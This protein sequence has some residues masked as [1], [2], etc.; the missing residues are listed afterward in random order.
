MVRYFDCSFNRGEFFFCAA[1]DE[2][3]SFERI[4]I[5]KNNLW[6]SLMEISG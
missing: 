6:S 5:Q 4:K 2:S 1:A 3:D